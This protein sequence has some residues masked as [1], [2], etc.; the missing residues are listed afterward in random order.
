MAEGK[1]SIFFNFWAQEDEFM[2]IV[3]AAWQA[4]VRGNPM[5]V[6]VQKLRI[7]KKALI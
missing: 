7:L 4:K 1:V 6:V 3:H 2:T 5:Y